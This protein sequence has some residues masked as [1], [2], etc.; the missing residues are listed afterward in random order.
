MAKLSAIVITKNE[1]EMIADCLISLEFAD[2]I[3][4]VDTGNTDETNSI[5]REHGAIVVDS[6]GNDYSHFRNAGLKA[7]TGDWVLYIDADERVTPLLRTEI[8]Q[9]LDRPRDKTGAYALV[10]NNIFLG[11]AMSYGGWGN[12]YVLRLFPKGNLH[13]WHNALHEQPEYTGKLFK[14]ANPLI[15]FSHRDLSS[16]LDKTL[17]FTAYEAKLRY[18]VNHPKI[19]PWRIARV[20][21]TEAWKRFIVLQAWKDGPEGVIDGLFQVFNTFV[22]YSRLWELQQ[23]K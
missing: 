9:I 18:D 17:E 2:E 11:K 23:A 7:A 5:A 4:V 13:S 12:D 22:I 10:R 20:M 6:N 8:Q 1:Q 15:H 14:L 21:F 16:M 19:V 3:I